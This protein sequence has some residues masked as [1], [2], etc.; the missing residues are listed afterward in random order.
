MPVL[1]LEVVL[2]EL[3]RVLLKELAPVKIT[4]SFT[5]KHGNL[6]ILATV[7]NPNRIPVGLGAISHQTLE[8]WQWYSMSS[9]DVI[10]ILLEDNLC[11]LVLGLKITTCNGHDTLICSIINMTS[12][13]SP[14]GNTFDMIKH[15]P[16]MLKISAG[17]HSP[18]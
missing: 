9:H 14:I 17:L 12:H 10:E 3:L 2:N 15:D 1:V 8:L 11:V 5:T 18:Y 7:D 6:G 13:C 4:R 16:G